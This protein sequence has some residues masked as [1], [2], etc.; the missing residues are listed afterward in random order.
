MIIL[1]ENILARVTE[2]ALMHELHQ[3]GPIELCTIPNRT[4]MH[5]CT[6]MKRII[7]LRARRAVRTGMAVFC[8]MVHILVFV[9]LVEEL[10]RDEQRNCGA[11]RGW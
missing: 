11:G 4:E 8:Q 2:L 9:A 5:G 10:A 6:G 3:M 7:D 1:G